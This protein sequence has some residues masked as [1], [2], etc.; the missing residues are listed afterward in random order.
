MICSLVVDCCTVAEKNISKNLATSY[1]FVEAIEC[2]SL[3]ISLQWKMSIA[4]YIAISDCM[5]VQVIFYN[6]ISQ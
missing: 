1:L 6:E 5:H 3:L 4:T 2:I